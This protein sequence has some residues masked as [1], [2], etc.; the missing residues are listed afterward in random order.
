[1][2]VSAVCVEAPQNI[3]LVG[4]TGPCSGTLEQNKEGKW[5]KVRA[6]MDEWNVTLAG[7]VCKELDCGAALSMQT[8]VNT[9]N[10]LQSPFQEVSFWIHCSGTALGSTHTFLNSS[11][12]CWI[13]A[14]SDTQ[15]IRLRS[16]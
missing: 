5:R 14:Y 10:R 6:K 13:F 3:R 8:S 11:V 16:H 1:M 9:E 2:C 15:M 7:S 12:V 4:G